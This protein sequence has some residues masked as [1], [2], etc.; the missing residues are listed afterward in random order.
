[1]CAGVCVKQA[2]HKRVWLSIGILI[3]FLDEK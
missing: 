3:S 2:V 1:M